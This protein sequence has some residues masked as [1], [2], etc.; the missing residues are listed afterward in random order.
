MLCLVAE[1]AGRDAHVFLLSAFF[2]GTNFRCSHL[3]VDSVC[4]EALSVNINDRAL[5]Q[6]TR[7]LGRLS[8]EVSRLKAT[9][10]QRLQNEYQNLVNGLI[11]QGLLDAPANDSTLVSVREQRTDRLDVR[12]R[13]FSHDVLFSASRMY[14]TRTLS[15]KPFRAISVGPSTLLAL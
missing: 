8:S 10:S 3:L 13:N 5:E 12:P 11:D 7:S 14:W 6:A 2:L 9:D 4:I 15:T 1:D